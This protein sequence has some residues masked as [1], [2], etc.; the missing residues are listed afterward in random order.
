M[1][2]GMATLENSLAI[3]YKIKCKSQ[4]PHSEVFTQDEWQGECERLY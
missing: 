2:N 4:K 1:K 3:S